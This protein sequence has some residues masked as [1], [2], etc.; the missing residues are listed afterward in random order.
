MDQPTIINVNDLPSLIWRDTLVVT[1]AQ[2][3]EF[4]GVPTT[5][6]RHNFNNNR[7]RFIEGIHYFKLEGSDL[8][9]FKNMVKNFPAVNNRGKIF[10][11]DSKVNAITLFTKRGAFRLAKSVNSDRAWEVYEVLE[12]NY[13]DRVPYDNKE[14]G[15][16]FWWEVLSA[17]SHKKTKDITD[18]ERGVSLRKLAS[19]TRNP[20]LR[21][22]IVAQATILIAGDL[23][24]PTDK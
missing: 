10:P 3:A 2:L 5:N 8:A 19:H 20:E 6:I 9:E 21:E 13:F 22:M 14:P 16:P 24:S 12:S 11:S 1:T 4:F 17:K 23:L 15:A 7:D 18:Y